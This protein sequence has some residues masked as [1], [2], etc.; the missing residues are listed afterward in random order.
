MNNLLNQSRLFLS[1]NASTIL[2][3]VGGVGV[4]ATTVLAVKAT[5]KALT[6]LKEA[7]EEKGEELT[8]LEVVK[9]AAPVYI[10]TALVGAST[11]ACMF[12]A[13]IL[14]KRQQAALISGYALIDNSYKEYKNKV[15]ELCGEDTDS[16]V[17]KEV[18]KDKYEKTDISV[19]DHMQLFYDEFSGRYFESTTEK[20][21]IAE[22]KLNKSVTNDWGAYLN[23]FYELLGLPPT[24]YGD[25]M[26]WSSSELYDTYWSSWVEFEH[27][28]VI[29]DDGL[30]CT[31]IT[32]LTDPTYDFE[33]Y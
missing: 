27:N 24:D 32:I 30:E 31:I 18:A 8:K 29:M 5:P 19:N 16:L 7:K 1:R 25:Y 9:V 11:L 20:V 15:K 10:P 2:T 12:G 22:S 17:R 4:V 26:G 28:K 33:N 6:L 23:D 3:C 14:N 21:L 13:T